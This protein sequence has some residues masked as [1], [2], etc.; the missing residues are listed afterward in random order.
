MKTSKLFT[1][2][3]EIAEELKQI[4]NASMLVNDLLHDYFAINKQNSSV[5]EQK[6]ASLKELKKK[7]VK[8]T[9]K[10]KL[11]RKL[12]RWASIIFVFVGRY[13]KRKSQ[14]ATK[15]QS[16]DGQECLES[17]KKTSSKGGES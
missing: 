2:D 13:L 8:L 7:A 12:K 15:S 14:Q 3:T 17:Q 5:I 16:M 4:D 10:L 11:L 9:K 6:Q 1:I